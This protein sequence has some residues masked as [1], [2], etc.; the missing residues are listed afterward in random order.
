MQ[1]FLPYPDFRDSAMV[2]DRLRLG[3]QRVETLQIM[4]ALLTGRGWTSHPATKMWRN[5]ESALLEYQRAIVREWMY[6]GY[7]DTCLEKTLEIY[8][9]DRPYQAKVVMPP[10]FGDPEFHLSHQSNL[11]RKHPVHYREYF[12]GVPDNL[13]YVWPV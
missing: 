11:L 8:A 10:W 13:P 3:K 7:R 5:Y 4:S 2:L 6:R 1:T 12:S 9:M